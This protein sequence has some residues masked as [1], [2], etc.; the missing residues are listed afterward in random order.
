[1]CFLQI[2]SVSATK[3]FAQKIARETS[4]KAIR[5]FIFRE[6]LERI[7]QAKEDGEVVRDEI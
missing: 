2:S 3:V 4:L 1:M 5:Q 7:E 6:L